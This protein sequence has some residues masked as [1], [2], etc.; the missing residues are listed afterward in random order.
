MLRFVH[1][2]VFP[3]YADWEPAHAIAGIHS[4]DWQREPGR[5]QVRTVAAGGGLVQSMGGVSVLPDLALSQLKDA[6]SALLILPGGPN[7]E[8]ADGHVEA[9][10]RAGEFIERGIPV[11][12]ICGATAGL[13]RRGWLDRRPHTSNAASY[14]AGTGYA[15]ADAYRD[16]A[17]VNDRGLITAAG[18]AS[19]DFAREIF[20]QLGLYEDEVLQAWTQLHKTGKSEYFARLQRAAAAA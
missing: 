18:T 19:V 2:Y 7:W 5:Y 3:G 6:D 11:A 16:E 1:L 20:L 13:A 10:D 4:P 9:L 15:G 12:A 8:D 14:L 17:V